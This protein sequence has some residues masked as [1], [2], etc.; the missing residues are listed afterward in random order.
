MRRLS[1][2]LIAL[3]L[4]ISISAQNRLSMFTKYVEQSF[5]Q[6]DIPSVAVAVVKGGKIVFARGYG[7]TDWDK[8]QKVD[9]NT[10]YPIGSVTKSFTALAIAQLVEQ[11][12]IKWDTHVIDIIPEFRLYNDYVT[13]HTTVEDLL[14]HRVGL[15]TFSGDLLWYHTDYSPEDIILRL[16]YLKPKFEFRNGFGYSNVMFLV[17]GQVVERVS[18]QDIETYFKQHIFKPLKMMRTTMDID[19]MEKE[20]NWAHGCY[21]TPEGKKMNVPYIPSHNIKAFGGINT[22]VAEL[23]NYLIMLMNGGEFDGQQIVSQAQINYLWKTHNPIGVSQRDKILH[24]SRHF[25]GYG[26]GWFV[27]DQNGYKIVTHSGGMDGALCRVLMIPEKKIGVIVLT[28]SMNFLYNALP[29][30]FADLFTSDKKPFDWNA[31]YLKLAQRYIQSYVIMKNEHHRIQGTRALPLDKYVG[32]YHSNMYGDILVSKDSNGLTLNFLPAP[33]LNATLTHWHY[34]TYE[35]HF[36][37][38]LMAIPTQWGLANFIQDQDGNISQ[39]RLVVPNYD[40]LFGE[41]K[42]KKISN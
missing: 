32:R 6:W 37:N 22:S 35:I 36:K 25:Y 8:R 29:E 12:K 26:L 9:K 27:Y 15:A 1:F 11:G 42:L 34:N 23:A 24:P 3:V 13:T 16:K 17:A 28:N 40:L 10:L 14:C 20:G 41:L 4:S 33:Y 2:L 38:P 7:Y 39:L 19:Q 31:Y 5:E 21:T 30:Y 18:G